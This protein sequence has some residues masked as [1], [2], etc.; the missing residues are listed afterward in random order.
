MAQKAFD[1][2]AAGIKDAIASA[3]GEGG[4]GRIQ[5]V[6]IPEV[7]V[8]AVRVKLGLSQ[9]DFAAAFGVSLGTVR[10][11]EQGRRHPEGPARA[12]LVVIDKAPKAVMQALGVGRH[13][14][15]AA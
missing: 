5:R 6:R 2:I 3:R 1:A 15:K 13:K 10:N 11:W 7:D 4:R 12:L 9:E 14:H 8:A